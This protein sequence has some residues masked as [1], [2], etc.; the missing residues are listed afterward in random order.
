MNEKDWEA[1]QDE[2]RVLTEKYGVKEAA[3]CGDA[4]GRFLGFAIHQVHT[5]KEIADIVINVGRL[6]QHFRG[7]IRD[8]LDDFERPRKE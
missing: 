6:W 7:V 2:M 5:A 4:D 1:F 8:I 3:F